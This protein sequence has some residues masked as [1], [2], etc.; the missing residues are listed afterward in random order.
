MII[1]IVID[2]VEAGQQCIWRRKNT[3][4]SVQFSI[5]AM[6]SASISCK[7]NWIKWL[8]VVFSCKSVWSYMVLFKL[9]SVACNR[10]LSRSNFSCCITNTFLRL[11]LSADRVDANRWKVWNKIRKS[12]KD[13]FSV[14]F[15][16]T[17]SAIRSKISSNWISGNLFDLTGVVKLP[18]AAITKTIDTLKVNWL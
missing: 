15:L 13:C 2:I 3:T 6:M 11:S 12:N 14:L 18:S 7:T 1:E 9:W 16:M 8:M 17:S 4:K 10:V 5:Y